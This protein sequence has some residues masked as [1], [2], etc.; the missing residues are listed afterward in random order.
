MRLA[1]LSD[2]I[3]PEG[4]GGAEAVVWRLAR[5][6]ADKGQDV[7]VV[8]TTKG[9]SFEEIR[10]DIPTY[11]IHSKYP[12]R[13][14]AWLS[15]WNP[16]TVGQLR[17][18]LR[19]LQ[20]Q[21]VNAH[22]IHFYLSYHALKVA[23]DA[24]A[25]TVFSA[26]D[27]MPF[28]YS[29]LRHYTR[30]GPGQV[31]LP[32]AYRLPRFYNLQRNRFRYNPWRNRAI[33]RCLSRYAERRTV[34]SQAL[35]EAFMVNG[36]PPAEV[37]HNGIDLREWAE[38]DRALVEELRRRFDLA[39]KQVI[40]IAGR[41]TPDKGTVP[42]L[43]A[44]DRLKEKLPGMRLLALTARD[45][46]EQI[47]AA[48]SHLRSLIRAGGWLNGAELRAAY[49]LADVV[50]VPS[51]IFDTFPTVNLEAMAAGKPVVATCF[52]GSPE[53]VIDGETGFIVNPFETA[54][55]AERLGRLLEDRDL[56][57]EMGR[58]GRARIGE[59][60]ALDRQVEQML[61]IYARARDD[62]GTS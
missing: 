16:V 48:Y 57:R 35:A 34:P 52:G 11:H 5:G 20:P 45:I 13:F 59:R 12:E 58:R 55:L 36:L 53:I 40:L 26:H 54:T 42:L 18:L 27:V 7:H 37:V 3:P 10:D 61:A 39:G 2:Q 19:R 8:A 46:D 56:S 33:R 28:A 51:V 4:A 62:R 29:K 23:R 32:D 60:F 31:I 41:L 21:V 38:A 1:L 50:A 49:E 24:G 25:A 43:K 14:R 17:A 22:N 15:L 30:G 6:L 44:M 9:A 47:P